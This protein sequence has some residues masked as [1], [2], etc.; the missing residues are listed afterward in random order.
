MKFNIILNRKAKNIRIKNNNSVKI[1]VIN[2][3]KQKRENITK[4]GGGEN[5]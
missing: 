5:L 3:I 1:I 4:I 2:R